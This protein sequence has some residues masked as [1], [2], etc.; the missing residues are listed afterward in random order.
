MNK[1]LLSINCILSAFLLYGCPP[2]KPDA[3]ASL[4]DCEVSNLQV[5]VNDR[6][7]NVSWENN[8]N[9][10]IAG[11]N[12]YISESA[13][14][15]EK[16][17]NATPFDGDT[18]PED[19]VENF[20]AENL[21]NV[22]KY[23]VSVKIVNPDQTLSVSSQEIL[24]VCGP[25]EEIELSVRYKSDQDGYSFNKNK[26][27]RADDVAND[28]YFYSKDGKDYIS[29]PHKLDGFLRVNKLTKMT[30]K[31]EF[32]DLRTQLK[33][34]TLKP[35]DDKIIVSK[36]DW[37]QL[38]TTDNRTALLKILGFTGDGETRK[39]K[40]FVAYSPLANELIF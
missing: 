39:I 9:K 28:L 6:M 38:K 36:N 19:G 22:K 30:Y 4:G 27:V 33:M 12:I 5:D 24:T 18:N 29:S 25:R 8:C 35:S 16:P 1:K 21:E 20:K 10:T 11:Y 40:L 32:D 7:M 13:D 23:F 26:Y 2:P 17:F 37:V 31:G 14:S 3:G 34:Y 15:N